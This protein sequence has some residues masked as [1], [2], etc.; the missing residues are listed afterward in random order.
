[1]TV[2]NRRHTHQIAEPIWRVL[3]GLVL[4]VGLLLGETGAQAQFTNLHTFT[5]VGTDGAQPYG[6]LAISGDGTKLYGMTYAGC[7]NNGM[8]F[9]INSD[10]SGF[11]NIHSFSGSGSD[12]YRPYCTPTLSGDGTTLYGTT[13]NGGDYM[14][15][16]V[17]KVCLTNGVESV[18]HM[19][20][21]NP[22][23]GKSP[24]SGVALSLDGQALYGATQSG[25]VSNKGTIFQVSITGSGFTNLHVFTGAPSDGSGLT[26]TPTLSKDG[27]TLYWSI[28]GGS[29]YDGVIQQY[30]LT[31]DILTTLYTF[32]GGADGFIPRGT[33][34]LSRDGTTLYGT[35]ANG[36]SSGKGTIFKINTTGSGYT[37][38]YTF[39][40]SANSGATP[41]GGLVISEDGQTLYGTTQYGGVSNKGTAFQINTDGSGYTNLYMFTGGN[42]GNGPL[43]LPTLSIDG[44]TLYGTTQLG[45]ASSNGTVFAVSL[46]TAKTVTI[47]ANPPSG[48]TVS[49]GGTYSTGSNILLTATA[50][51]YWNFTGWSD[52][53]TNNPYSITVPATNVSYTANF[54][55]QTGTVSV[56]A[57][58]MAGGSVS[59]S[60]TYSTGSNILLTATASLYWNFTGWSDG[61]TNNPYSITVPATNVS[62]TANFEVTPLGILHAFTGGSDGGNP[63]ASLTL[64]ENGTTLYGM[65]PFGGANG[66][67]TA[68]ALDTN[69]V[70]T[71]LHAFTGGSE[72]SNP[73]ASLT[74]SKDKTTLY[75]TTAYG[76]T[77][78]AGTVF[79]LGTNGVF[80]T[81]HTFTNGSDGGYPYGS[82]TLSGDGK[83][84]YGTT[85]HGGANGAGTVFALGTNGVF[86]TLYA[87]TGGSDGGQPSS[88][89][90]L[91][92]DGATLAGMTYNGGSGWGTAFTVGTN[93]VFNLLHTFVAAADGANP[94]GSLTLSG[95]GTLL[96]GTTPNYGANFYGTVFALGTNGVFTTLYAFTGGSDGGN[97][98]G[99][100]TLSQGGTLL[101]GTVSV[102][103]NNSGLVFQMNTDGSGLTTVYSFSGGIDGKS[104]YGSLTLSGDGKTLYGM[105]SSAGA[106]GAGTAFEL[107]PTNQPS[108][109]TINVAANPSPQDR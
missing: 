95:D 66:Y 8:V 21:V 62:Y 96:Y 65:T 71:T 35:T 107:T 34:V 7:A 70:F 38:L 57:S 67:G 24:Y 82:L 76:G 4:V 33:M 11:T 104:P 22:N 3:A 14:Y 53:A 51:L 103:G 46:P 12:G 106:N 89:L 81:I 2:S 78:G 93:G 98:K 72:G 91:L 56:A 17:M 32:T 85:V 74:L 23:D 54:I 84:L 52:G 61:A 10:G 45:G 80:T 73:N 101:Y 36:G 5:G 86:T 6:G 88:S 55:H 100:I 41:V 109:V 90:T 94:Q 27:K 50:S 1:M 97:P 43:G 63:N 49:G 87:F 19:F 108:P 64:L 59:G 47:T 77:N 25:G 16:T 99:S 69:G 105:A 40:G 20:P 26:G 15:G 29:T 60:G 28:G 13:G 79:A 18:L 48:G 31:N 42:D 30:C 9:Q 92:R 39:T 44:K 68:F 58:P 83:T 37:N 75:G 102:G